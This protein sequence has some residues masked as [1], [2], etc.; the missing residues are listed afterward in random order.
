[1]RCTRCGKA[2]TRSEGLKL[3]GCGDELVGNVVSFGESLP[4]K[5]LWLSFEHSRKSNLFIAMGSSLVVTPAADMPREAL[6]SDARLVAI[7]QGEAP[8]DQS[9]SLRFYEKIGNVLPRAVKRLKGRIDL[10]E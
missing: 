3:C 2:T 6:L 7:N 5:D 10:F 8:F 9:A 4:E 1:M